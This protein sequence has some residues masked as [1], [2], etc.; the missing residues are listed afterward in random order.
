MEGRKLRP[1]ALSHEERQKGAALRCTTAW[2]I[3]E[4]AC[5]RWQ[6]ELMPVQVQRRLRWGSI[7]PPPVLSTTCPHTDGSF[8]LSDGFPTPQSL[9]QSIYR[10]PHRHGSG[11]NG[12][13][14]KSDISGGADCSNLLCKLSRDGRLWIPFQINLNSMPTATA[15]GRRRCE[16]VS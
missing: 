8:G 12:G 6:S 15:E 10:N 11:A 1:V 2:Q 9:M 14:S 13:G 4:A 16:G 5:W 7:D 3:R